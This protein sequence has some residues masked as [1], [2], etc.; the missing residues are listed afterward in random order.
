[1]AMTIEA[2]DLKLLKSEYTLKIRE[3]SNRIGR[4]EKRVDWVE[5]LLWLSAGA[6]ISWLV[7]WLIR[8]L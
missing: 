7:T 8:S 6:V 4:V 2:K 5:K 3:V 1:M